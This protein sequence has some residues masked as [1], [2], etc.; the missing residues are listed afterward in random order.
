M[1]SSVRERTCRCTLH[2]SDTGL[3]PLRT[4]P[5]WQPDPSWADEAVAGGAPN[6]IDLAAAPAALAQYGSG[7]V[8]AG[9][10]AAR[11]NADT[12][13]VFHQEKLGLTLMGIDDSGAEAP[14]PSAPCAYVMVAGVV[15]HYLR[16]V[17]LS[18]AMGGQDWNGSSCCVQLAVS[19]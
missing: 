16:G 12:A 13:F 6:L 7:G 5:E 3:C 1:P 9:G 17:A 10:G 2:L 11:G 19:I 4:A 15:R 8:P 14:S 18:V